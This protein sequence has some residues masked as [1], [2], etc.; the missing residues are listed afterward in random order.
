MQGA[1]LKPEYHVSI[2]WDSDAAVWVATSEHIPGLVLESVSFD[3]L[4]ERVRLAAP[5]LMSLNAHVT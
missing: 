1:Q 4:V 3:L 5:E 2:L